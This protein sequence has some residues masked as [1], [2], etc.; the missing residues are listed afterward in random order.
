[1]FTARYGL[2]MYYV[3]GF[4]FVLIRVYPSM[5]CCF[6]KLKW[7]KPGYF[8]KSSV[9]AEIVDQVIQFWFFLLTQF[10]TLCHN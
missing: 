7:A 10:I 2:D 5:W 8:P 1:V 9:L 4:G 3:E 6:Q